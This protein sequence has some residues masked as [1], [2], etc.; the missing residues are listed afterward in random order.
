MIKEKDAARCILF[1]C[2]TYFIYCFKRK[3]L[4]VGLAHQFVEL[5]LQRLTSWSLLHCL[6]SLELILKHLDCVVCFLHFFVSI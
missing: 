5:H 4:A 3:A 1:P 6:V 2:Y